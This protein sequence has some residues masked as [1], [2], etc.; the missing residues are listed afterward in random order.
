MNEF[1]FVS[2]CIIIINFIVTYKG[3]TNHEFMEGFKFQVDAILV[4]KDY[5]R[6]ITSSFLH[7]SWMHLILNMMSLYIFSEL[8]ET[9]IGQSAFLI[10]YFASLIGG[11]L[12]ALYIH[13]NHG[14][15]SSV[16]ASGAVCGITFATIAL[17][18]GIEIGFFGLPFQIPGWI[19]GLLYIGFSIWGIKSRKD[20]IGHDAHLGGALVGLITAVL[21][22]PYT[23]KYNYITILI[24]ALPTLIFIYF[25]I[26]HP[27]LLLVDNLFSKSHQ[28]YYNID[29]K[30]N[31]QK[32]NNQI[33]LDVLLDKINSKGLH[34]LTKKEIQRL[35]ELSK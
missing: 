15:Y 35:K 6:L 2:T 10:I 22:F 14:D 4:K 17:F 34:Q 21:I 31:M 9:E 18:P 25:I 26:T 19:Y 7:V 33:E 8:L 12:L 1:S 23:L 29:Q 13:R 32:A 16:G 27:H 3:L 5:K 28:T 11:D 30:Y 24:I 20:N